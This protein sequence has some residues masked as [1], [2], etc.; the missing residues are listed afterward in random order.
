[1]ELH[2]CSENAQLK[3]DRIVNL[4]VPILTMNT[5][6]AKIVFSESF[7]PF[8]LNLNTFYAP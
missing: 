5:N 1:M 4:H 2:C 7:I 3:I 6:A 8:L